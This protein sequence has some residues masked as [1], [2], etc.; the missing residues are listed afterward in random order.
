MLH[1]ESGSKARCLG[2]EKFAETFKYPLG[3]PEAAAKR[4]HA[5][6]TVYRNAED[7]KAEDKTKGNKKKE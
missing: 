1:L 5:I 6:S 4:P 3:R 2:T 7:K